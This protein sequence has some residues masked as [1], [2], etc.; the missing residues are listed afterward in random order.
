MDIIEKVS[1]SYML[2]DTA[3]TKKL[4][5]SVPPFGVLKINRTIINA[6]T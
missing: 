6:Q 2:N 1:H 4:I 3:R 5:S